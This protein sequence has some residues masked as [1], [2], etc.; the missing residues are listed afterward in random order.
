LRDLS[1]DSMIVLKLC[2][3]ELCEG[4]VWNSVTYDFK[5]SRRVSA[6]KSSREI[7]LLNVEL[8]HDVSEL[9]LVSISP[10]SVANLNKHLHIF[11][12]YECLRKGK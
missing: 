4:V 8:R 6:L 1:I 12:V 9:A 3:R 10:I 7:D 11:R 2:Y 5:L